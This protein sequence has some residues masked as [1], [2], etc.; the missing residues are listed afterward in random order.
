ML[1]E[2][3]LPSYGLKI[4][5]TQYAVSNCKCTNAQQARINAID[6]IIKNNAKP[7][8]FEGVQKELQGIKTGYDYV[9]EMEQS[10][11]GL[12]KA[13]EALQK[14][15]QNPNLDAS[16]RS[17]IESAVQRGQDVLNAMNKTLGR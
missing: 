3:A 13:T 1:R 12:E 15:L 7:H 11:R 2:T 14:S 16:V 4:P 17:E 8:D 9:T 6:N 5:F 10:V